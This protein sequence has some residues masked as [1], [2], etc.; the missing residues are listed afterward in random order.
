MKIKLA[1]RLS[2][3]LL[4]IFYLRPFTKDCWA[5]PLTLVLLLHLLVGVLTGALFGVQT[6]LLVVLFL[7]I[8]AVYGLIG[9]ASIGLG[10]WVGAG[11]VLQLGYLGGVFCEACSSGLPLALS[12]TRAA[13]FRIEETV[14]A[15]RGAAFAHY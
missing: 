2:Q 14:G 6:L 7:P 4:K 13:G 15:L 8:E 10:W 3:G 12:F 9:R 1:S 11:I 5:T